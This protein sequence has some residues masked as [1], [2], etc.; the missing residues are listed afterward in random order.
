MWI[1]LHILPAMK[2]TTRAVSL[3]FKELPVLVQHKSSSP[4][5]NWVRVWSDQSAWFIL[6]LF[7]T[8]RRTENTLLVCIR[9]RKRKQKQRNSFMSNKSHGFFL[10][11]LSFLTLFLPDLKENGDGALPSTRA[12]PPAF[13]QHLTHRCHTKCPRQF[14]FLVLSGS[15]SQPARA[16]ARCAP[17]EAAPGGQGGSRRERWRRPFGT[18][19]CSPCSPF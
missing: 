13:P 15:L 4:T 10:T 11:S 14:S 18:A 12:V 1:Y 5:R 17:P 2:E 3:P 7:H 16:E 8:K 6:N 19:C 9:K